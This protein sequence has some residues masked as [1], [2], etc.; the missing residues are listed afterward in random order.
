MPYNI[1]YSDSSNKTP[2]TVYDNT[3]NIETSLKYAGRN[4]SGY[5]QLIAENFLHLLENFANATEPSNPVE[6]QIWYDND[7]G[8]LKLWDGTAW[9]AASN[10]SKSTSEPTLNSSKAG[11]L[12]INL[13]NNQLNIFDGSKWVLVGPD[14]SS[15]DG[16]SYGTTVEHIKDTD[17]I[18]RSILSLYVEDVPV[19][20]ISKDTFTPNPLIVGFGQLTSGINMN[21]DSD[22]TK[23]S[24]GFKP[25]LT[26]TASTASALTVNGFTVPA[27][28]FMRSD[29]MSSTE[30]PINIRH[31]S[32]ITIGAESE[33]TAFYTTESAKLYNTV[34]GSGIDLQTNIN[35]TP[36]TTLRVINDKVG[37]NN[38]APSESLDVTGNIRSSGTLLVNNTTQTSIKTLGGLSVA[39]N[40][41]VGA[42]LTITGLTTANSNIIPTTTDSYILGNAGITPKRWKEIHVKT[43][44]TEQ[45]SG[46]AGSLTPT[47]FG[48]NGGISITKAASVGETLTV[49]GLT[50]VSANIIPNST[51]TIL[52]GTA[53]KRWNEVYAKTVYTD[54]IKNSA[55]TVLTMPVGTISQFA[56]SAVPVGY[57]ACDGSEKNRDD[58][59]ALFAVIGETYKGSTAYVG[60]NVFRV[61]SIANTGPFAAIRYIIKA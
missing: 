38:L 45:L 2:I 54:T 37:I 46:P 50:T 34:S 47:T 32:G 4:F 5:G 31:N 61:P 59:S 20:I 17:G 58:Y 29:K 53:S 48:I 18:D 6:G 41:T 21:T 26:G 57:L 11:Q 16:K 1:D 22:L 25:Q 52:L 30:Y 27:V 15:K 49:T 23:F 33:F 24:G 35:G 60:S 40:I 9:Q 19:L 39:K 8:Y 36:K 3:Q 13:A 56:G 51:D 12:Y 44:Y 42:D 14:V 7:N 10:I 43:V 28:N 55:G